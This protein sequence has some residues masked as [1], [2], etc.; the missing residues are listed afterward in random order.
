VPTT[1]S[2]DTDKCDKVGGAR[3]GTTHANVKR[4]RDETGLVWAGKWVESVGKGDQWCL[5]Q[6]S[7]DLELVVTGRSIGTMCG[8]P[9]QAHC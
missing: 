5:G 4:G 8:C 6:Q 9:L 1:S 7:V 2:K 3:L